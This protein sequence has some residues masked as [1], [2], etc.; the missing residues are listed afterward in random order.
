M[1]APQAKAGSTMFITFDLVLGLKFLPPKKMAGTIPRMPMRVAA[2]TAK[3]A[4]M[5]SPHGLSPARASSSCGV[6]RGVQM[7]DKGARSCVCV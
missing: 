5:A 4:P 7:C 1:R 6:N 2:L 3:A